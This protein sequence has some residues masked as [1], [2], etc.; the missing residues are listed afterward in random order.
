[1]AGDD[2]NDASTS[3]TVTTLEEKTVPDYRNEAASFEGTH[4][5]GDRRILR[6]FTVDRGEVAVDAIYYLGGSRLMGIREG[7]VAVEEA[8]RRAGGVEA[9]CRRWHE[10]D[11]EGQLTDDFDEVIRRNREKPWVRRYLER[12][13]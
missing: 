3:A 1:M 5:R 2:S 6:R 13:G 12:T 8:E 9:F 7:T 10:R 11:V 4:E